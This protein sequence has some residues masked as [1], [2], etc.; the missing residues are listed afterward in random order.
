MGDLIEAALILLGER[1][2]QF[3]YLSVGQTGG[4]L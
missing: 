4:G 2:P 3:D 1:L